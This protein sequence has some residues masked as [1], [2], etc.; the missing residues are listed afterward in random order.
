M[1]KLLR[2]QPTN[3][4]DNTLGG[5]VV[6]NLQD[7]IENYA[8]V[9]EPSTNYNNF[10]NLGAPRERED[11]EYVPNAIL[12]S[13]RKTQAPMPMQHFKL[14]SNGGVLKEAS[15]VTFAKYALLALF[16][17]ISVTS[18]LT[19]GVLTIKDMVF[20]SSTVDTQF[21]SQLATQN[22]Q[23]NQAPN[24]VLGNAENSQSEPLG[25][26]DGAVQNGTFTSSNGY[27]Q[28][29][30]RLANEASFPRLSSRSYL[31][32]DLETG[33]IIL[34]QNENLVAPIA[35]VT[36]LMTAVVAEE[37]MD[38]QKIAI[39]SRDSY[40]T[41]GA[42]GK[43]LLGEKIKV[44]DLMY[45]LLMESSND[46]A[47]VIADAYDK[48][49]SAFMAL[50]NK[51]AVELG[52]NDTYYEDP[53]G[54]NPKNVSSIHDL[55]KLGRYAYQKHPNL[56]SMTRVRQYAILKHTWF[57]QNRFL[58]YDTF[59]GGKNGFIDEAKK[60]TVSIFDVTMARGGKRPVV[61]VL[62]KSDDR[63]GD[64]V[65]IINFLKKN[66]YYQEMPSAN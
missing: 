57:N 30:Y 43:L 25:S 62:L 22:S 60:T 27:D 64:A 47:E 59:L 17:G 45:P 24:K 11:D 19:Q 8:D 52:M 7:G 32:A 20:N 37:N 14:F 54:L 65:K 48:G 56:Y 35:S 6:D 31:A 15:N 49:N 34:E 2:K 26:D 42:Q 9:E 50:M 10:A 18:F 40:N 1:D 38:L 4:A 33:E 55:L 16:I 61:I 21:N 29:Q 13:N 12:K 51:K 39:V 3:N 5:G 46:A 58:N 44:Y 23:N 63:E 28:N 36:K 41:Y 66:A 53:S